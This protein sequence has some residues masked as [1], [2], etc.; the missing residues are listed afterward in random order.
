M[1]IN[2][3]LTAIEPMM[4]MKVRYLNKLSALG[5]RLTKIKVVV[6][7]LPAVP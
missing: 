5:P 3:I 7:A 2:Y 4:M 1:I 6:A